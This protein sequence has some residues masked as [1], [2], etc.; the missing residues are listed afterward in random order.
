MQQ[1]QGQEP[2]IIVDITI[3]KDGWGA[4]DTRGNTYK[5]ESIVIGAGYHRR[6]MKYEKFFLKS[7]TE[8]RAEIL[9]SGKLNIIP[10]YNPQ[11][12]VAD[13]NDSDN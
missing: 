7:E 2:N 13:S 8:C 3:L 6:V 11:P 10:L 5:I 4:K 1:E 9:P 12:I